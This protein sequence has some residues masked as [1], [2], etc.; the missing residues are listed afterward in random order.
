M[1]PWKQRMEMQLSEPHAPRVLTLGELSRA[2]SLAR[3]EPV[4]DPTLHAWIRDAIA[5]NRLAPVIRGIYLNRFIHPAG[6]LADAAAHVRR[7]AVVSLH[8]ALDEAG[9]L[10]N[11][12]A[13]VT[14]V[15]P[16]D[17]G[18]T[19]PRVG[20]VRTS[21]GAI[22][23][24]AMPRAILEAGEIEDRLDL[25]R[26]PAHARATPEKA[27]LDW[28]YLA[29]SPRSALAPPALHDVEHDAL[30]KRRLMRLARAMQ[31]EDTLAQWLRGEFTQKKSGVHRP[32]QRSSP[33]PRR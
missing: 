17:S 10:N 24:H 1:I 5:R 4:P 14:A 31:L 15:L 29:K 12:P 13:G 6:R 2:A 16:L 19:R 32:V 33:V 9:M 11:P 8:S 22:Q 18:P 3:L 25:G 28:L 7:D 20:R 21:A 27:L 30:N 23:F 26:G